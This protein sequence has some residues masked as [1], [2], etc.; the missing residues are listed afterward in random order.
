[1]V[2]S[3]KGRNMVVVGKRKTRLFFVSSWDLLQV[4]KIR[5]ASKKKQKRMK[6]KDVIVAEKTDNNQVCKIGKG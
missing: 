5:A 1:M 6:K 2:G 3:G 4:R